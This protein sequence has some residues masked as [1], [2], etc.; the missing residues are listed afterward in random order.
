MLPVRP[1]SSEKGPKQKFGGI[2]GGGVVPDHPLGKISQETGRE[3]ER[4]NNRKKTPEYDALLI[5]EV[6]RKN[7]KLVPLG[8]G[9]GKEGAGEKH[10]RTE[11]RKNGVKAP[12]NQGLERLGGGGS[13]RSN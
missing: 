4:G 5:P 9:K 10:T 12:R 8:C 1:K 2:G 11:G 7:E 3:K 13:Q 6:Y